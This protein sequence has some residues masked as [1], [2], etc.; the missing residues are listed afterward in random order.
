MMQDMI[1]DINIGKLFS[2]DSNCNP[3][4]LTIGIPSFQAILACHSFKTSEFTIA[5]NKGKEKKKERDIY[6]TL[7]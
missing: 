5:R 2:F 3:S 1:D 4:P 6:H 7:L